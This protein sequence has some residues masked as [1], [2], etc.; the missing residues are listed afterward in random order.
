MRSSLAVGLTKTRK[1]LVSKD[2]T[3]SFM[4]EGARVYAT[5]AMLSDIEHTCRDLIKE[6]VS[7]AEDSV[8]FDVSI[9]HLAPTLLDMEVTITA[10][11]T[12]VEGPKVVFEIKASDPGD[13]ICVGS[14]TR[15]VVDIAKTEQ[16]LQ[17]KKEKLENSNQT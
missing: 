10:T 8:G 5:P 17:A 2:K 13:K 7:P 16:R 3:I 15:F 6:H 12:E 4:G 14:H 1:I 11:I 9:K